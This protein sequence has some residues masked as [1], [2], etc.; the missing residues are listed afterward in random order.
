MILIR[1]IE[2]NETVFIVQPYEHRPTTKGPTYEM[3]EVS[4]EGGRKTL[5]YLSQ[6]QIERNGLG[7]HAEPER[8]EK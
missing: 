3:V 5:G 8:F 1:R 2:T 7:R 6:A 4:D